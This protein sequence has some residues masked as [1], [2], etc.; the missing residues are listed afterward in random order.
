MSLT[1]KR[2]FVQIITAIGLATG[3]LYAADSLET[4]IPKPDTPLPV[5][6]QVKI[7]QLENGLKYYIRHNAEP[8]N[9]AEL[10]LAINAGSVLEEDDQQGLAHFVEHM[11]FNG[12]RHFPKQALVNYLE[13]I[14][15]QF[16]ADLNAYTS[17]DETVYMLQIPTDSAAVVD[18]AL[19]IIADWAN[20]LLFDPQE[21]EKERG[22]IVEEWRLGRGANAR[23]MNRHF[24]VLFHQSRYAER[25]PIG[26][27]EIIE[28]APPERLRQ[29]YLDW[30]RPDL[31][32][33]VAVGDFD[34]SE[35]EQK[36]KAVFT[37]VAKPDNPKPRPVYPVPDHSETLLSIAT[38]PEATYNSIAI[39]YKKPIE[40]EQSHGAYRKNLIRT[41]HHR[42]LNERLNELLYSANPPFL[43]AGVS[44]GQLVRSKAAVTL[45][46]VVKDGG[47]L[48]G[49]EAL[50]LEARRI[51]EYGV[52]ATE[53][54]RQ[55]QDMLRSIEE[56]YNE[57]DKT[58]SQ[59]FAAEYLRNFLENEPIPGIEYE[60]MLWQTYLPGITLNEVNRVASDLLT[61]ENRVVLISAPEKDGLT[62]PSEDEVHQVF[63]K[64]ELAEITPYSENISDESLLSENPVTGE[65]VAEVYDDS[66]GLYQWRLNNGATV[67]AKPTDFK[68]DQVLFRAF[69]PGGLSLYPDSVYIS[70]KV[71]ADIANYSGLGKFDNITLNKKLSGID[72]QVMAYINSLSEGLSGSA[73]PRDL[74]T[75][76]Q[77]VYLYFTEPRADS[78]AY[79]FLQHQIMGF[80]EN[81]DASPEAAYSDTIRAVMSSHHFRTRP[82]QKEMLAQIDLQT[83]HRIFKERFNNAGDFTFIFVGNI[84]I[85]SLKA[86]V[87]KYIGGLPGKPVKEQWRDEHIRPPVGAIEKIVH[88]G[89][90]DKAV[91]TMFLT[92]PMEW[93]RRERLKLSMLASILQIRLREVLREDEGGVYSVSVSASP[94]HYPESRYQ[95]VIRYG[96]APENVSTLRELTM[97]EIRKMV[98][99]EISEA[100]F[101]K[102]LES[103][104]RSDEVEMRQNGAWLSKLYFYLWHAENLRQILH[105]PAIL[106]TFTV[107]S[108]KQAAKKY[109]TTPNI[110]T[111]ILLPEK[112]NPN[113]PK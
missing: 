84:E 93:E 80:L 50:L 51:R 28:T 10:R 71:V 110:A 16:G 60:Y 57:R 83:A 72:A 52:T 82:W 9:R 85:D 15:M 18:T 8:Q 100:D 23:L 90:E 1:K 96:C 86:L 106:D 14:G 46:A 34:V 53:L 32:A 13:S 17:F 70:A 44:E 66:L 38:D 2:M 97:A 69:S 95:F 49:M 67:I 73:S 35:M 78:T 79:L 109:L 104:R 6:K 30:Y 21:V 62:L 37:S 56:I 7:G 12:T 108:I 39:Y 3:W 112:F 27:K 76:F 36:I 4:A 107:E 111:F 102:V 87:K 58:A 5:D 94:E 63:K 11:A 25:L 68:N 81:R 43:Y 19:Q 42:I 26:K 24:P 103:L 54:E 64:V 65:I 48:K 105:T 113:A 91:V 61:D 40:D 20:G 89:L 88:K 74:E 55:K 47:I 77:L 75:L 29:F 98:D 33:V 41:L 92:G 101:H 22:V 31:M 59:A 45:S 99:G